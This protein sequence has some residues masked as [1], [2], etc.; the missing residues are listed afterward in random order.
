M[1]EETEAACLLRSG[2]QYARRAGLR[3]PAGELVFVGVKRG[4]LS[5]YVDDAP[6]L[7][8]DLEG[9]WQRLFEA[10]T[11]Y[12]KAL[13]GGIDAIDRVRRGPNLVLGRR[14]L[15][16]AEASDLDADVRERAIGLAADLDAG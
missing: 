6:I 10:G 3:G 13:D 8:F 5:I 1:A 11:H 14:A 16:Y 15:S 7:H 4:A 9:R 12:R 2:A